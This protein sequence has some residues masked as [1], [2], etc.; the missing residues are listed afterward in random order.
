M[1]V[2]VIGS[3]GR[4]HALGWK[5][6]QSPHI[7]SLIFAPGNPGMDVLGRCVDIKVTDIERLVDL[8]VSEQVSLVVIGPEEPLTLGLADALR[9][10]NIAVFGP[11]QSAARL[12]GSKAYMKDLLKRADVPTA[13]YQTFSDRNQARL[14]IDKVGAPIVVKTDGLAAGKGVIVAMTKQEAYQAVES[15]LVDGAFGAAGSEIIIEEFMDGEEISFFALSDGKT[16]VPFGTAQDHKRVGDGDTGPNTGGMGAYSPARLITPAL[17]DEII[18]TCIKPVVE[19]MKRDGCPFTGVLFAGIMVVDGVPKVLEFNIRFGDPE[20]QTLMRRFKGDLFKV[21]DAC[22]KGTLAHTPENFSFSSDVALTVVMAAQGYPGSYVKN[23]LIH[24][25]ELA[26]A[27]QGVV[28]FH[29]GTARDASGQIVNSGGRVLSVTATAQTVEKA[30][31]TAY[32]G[33]DQI[34]WPYGF[35]RRDIGW[36]AA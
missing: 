14:Y 2:L 25:L 9:A 16:V 10:H 36:R 29:A 26:G 6:A 15:M 33:V 32:Q 19:Q 34:D 27:I 7:Q 22:A 24:G 30:K 23:T 1:K 20:C 18:R 21:L 17:E 31:K 3:G 13:Q 8:A 12:E 11:S 28:V 4:E 5:L 35:C